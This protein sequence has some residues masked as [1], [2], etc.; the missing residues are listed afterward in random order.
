MAGMPVFIL[1][2]L[3]FRKYKKL[4]IVFYGL[5]ILGI[6]SFIMN[7]VILE[8]YKLLHHT[9]MTFF[10]R[11]LNSFFSNLGTVTFFICGPVLIHL[12]F[13]LRIRE[14]SLISGI[15]AFLSIVSDYIIPDPA[16]VLFWILTILT[17]LYMLVICIW[18]Y[19]T[20]GD[21]FLRRSIKVILILSSVNILF[22]I[23]SLI[24]IKIYNEIS[25]LGVS[26]Y[27]LVLNILSIVFCIKFFG[28]DS[29][30]SETGVSLSFIEKFAI[31]PREVEIINL[32]MEGQSVNTLGETLF[33]S[34]KTVSNHIHNIYQKTGVKNRIQM[35]NL[36]KS[37]S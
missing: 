32:L 25:T 16:M 36:I 22:L 27:F 1:T 29:Y 21:K 37:R 8:Y 26:L 18:K 12:F 9:E 2:I 10:L 31:T 7:S 17:S 35:V 34:P 6:F 30:L 19:P 15:V 23:L 3:F 5:F 24:P 11:F 28:Q 20:I 4:S 33:I 13:G 14:I